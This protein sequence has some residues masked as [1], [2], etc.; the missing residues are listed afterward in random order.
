MR[1]PLIN[2]GF[3]ILELLIVIIISAILLIS[4]VPLLTKTFSSNKI[5]AISNSIVSALH[6][7]RN[8]AI[9]ENANIV[10][11]KSANGKKCGGSW[12][13]YLLVINQRTKKPLRVFPQL[14][15]DVEL[16]WKG[17][18]G[19]NSAVTFSSEG[20]ATAGSFTLKIA[21]QETK[22]I[23]SSTGRIRTEL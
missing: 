6:F 10:L 15:S 5:T 11:C 14:A 7:A 4:S 8:S 19:K 12:N 17:G 1:Q 23:V 22:I 2:S 3:T 9:K 20:A 18:F 21:D 16:T 13:D